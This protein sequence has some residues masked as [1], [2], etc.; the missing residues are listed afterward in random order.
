MT[1]E[2]PSDNEIVEFEKTALAYIE[3][4]DIDGIADFFA[5]D[6]LL[7]NPGEELK[8]GRQHELDALS[9][10]IKTE[11][12]EMAFEPLEGRVSASED[13]AWVHGRISMKLP[14]GSSQSEKYITI[15]SKASGAWK[16]VA[17][18][19]NSNA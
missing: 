4:G 12:L 14:D 17:Q 6:F 2:S 15:W 5:D 16:I 18:I 11:G 7:F 1:E 19:R 13:M 9:A 10:A 3:A 8:K